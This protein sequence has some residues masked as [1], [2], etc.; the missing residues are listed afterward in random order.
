[1][2]SAQGKMDEHNEKLMNYFDRMTDE[3]IL[4]QILQYKE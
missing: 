4:Q 2:Q 1:M 3:A